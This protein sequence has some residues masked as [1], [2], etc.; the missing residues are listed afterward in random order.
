M[1][2]Y[3][4][5]Q[6]RAWPFPAGVRHCIVPKKGNVDSPSTDYKYLNGDHGAE[7]GRNLEQ[8]EAVKGTP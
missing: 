7:S 8:Q 2:D 3:D 5:A 1:P 4:S 6:K